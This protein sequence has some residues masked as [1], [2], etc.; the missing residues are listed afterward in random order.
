MLRR[1][2][3]THG[4]V[5]QDIAGYPFGESSTCA[6][7]GYGCPTWRLCRCRWKR[8]VTTDE[9]ASVSELELPAAETSDPRRKWREWAPHRSIFS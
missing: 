1:P 8:G 5:M 6:G 4:C 3:F 2:G 7:H 9:A